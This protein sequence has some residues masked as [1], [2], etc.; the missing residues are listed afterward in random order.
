MYITV[1]WY[2][3]VCIY[4][5]VILFL[6]FDDVIHI[7][8]LTCLIAGVMLQTQRRGL[9][10]SLEVVQSLKLDQ[11]QTLMRKT[12]QQQIVSGLLLS[13]IDFIA[14]LTTEG[15]FLCLCCPSYGL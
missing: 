9:G 8:S 11:C 3:L 7:H 12:L 6:F 2:F 13:K 1:P 14:I 15:S 10:K 5:V 4:V